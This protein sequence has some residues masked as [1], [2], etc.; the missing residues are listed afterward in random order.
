M[1]SDQ[2]RK[3]KL[4]SYPENSITQEISVKYMVLSRVSGNA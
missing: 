3:C 2:A 1:K 4:S